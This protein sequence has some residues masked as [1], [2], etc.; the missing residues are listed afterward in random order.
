IQGLIDSM[1]NKTPEVQSRADEILRT[2]ASLSGGV[3]SGGSRSSGRGA[4]KGVPLATGMEYVPYDGM[5]A[6]LHRGEA[7]LTAMEADAW[8]ELDGLRMTETRAQR[9]SPRMEASAG[10]VL[11]Y[12]ALASAI[13]EA[14]P[15]GQAPVI[16]LDGAVVGRMVEPYVSSLQGDRV[17]SGRFG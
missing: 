11:D 15:E 10:A 5:P 8:R 17:K 12:H 16:A 7:V 9:Q 14:A 4:Q 13:W 6:V 3:S 1:D 2:V